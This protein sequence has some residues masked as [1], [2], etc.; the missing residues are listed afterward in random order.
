MRV[1]T[2]KAWWLWNL[3]KYSSS[4]EGAASRRIRS[5]LPKDLQKVIESEDDPNVKIVAI[6]LIAATGDRTLIPFLS[7]FQKD[8]S[9]NS[10]TS[11]F[12]VDEDELPVSVG[13]AAK[14]AIAS[15]EKL[16]T[17]KAIDC[18]KFPE[19]RKVIYI[20]NLSR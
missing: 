4:W 15:L 14:A 10:L 7:K 9:V 19:D 2:E 16:T 13:E 18:I 6:N 17:E 1:G 8:S 12:Q 5:C 11:S 3:Y 20:K